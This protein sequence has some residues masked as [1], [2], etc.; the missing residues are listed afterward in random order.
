MPLDHS[1]FS[2]HKFLLSV[3]G[4]SLCNGVC[5]HLFTHDHCDTFENTCILYDLLFIFMKISIYLYN[6]LNC[7]MSC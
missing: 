2:D 5:F 4:L 6:N 7:T 3:C 1:P